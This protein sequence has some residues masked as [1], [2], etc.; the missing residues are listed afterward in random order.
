MFNLIINVQNLFLV[1]KALTYLVAFLFII[2]IPIECIINAPI[3]K[4]T[5]NSSPYIKFKGGD[6]IQGSTE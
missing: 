1:K 2:V 6:F 5:E 4:A 3:I